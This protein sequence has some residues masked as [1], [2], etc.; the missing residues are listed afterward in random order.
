MQAQNSDH[1]GEMGWLWLS[2][3]HALAMLWATFGRARSWV[4]HFRRTSGFCQ[5]RADE[6][7]LWANKFEVGGN[8]YRTRRHEQLLLVCGDGSGTQ[9]DSTGRGPGPGVGVHVRFDQS[10][11]RAR[12]SFVGVGSLFWPKSSAHFYSSY[13]CGC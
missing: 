12:G 9:R 3:Y 6:P 10:G 2:L 8:R 11:N 7:C 1:G 4:H 5:Q 13:S